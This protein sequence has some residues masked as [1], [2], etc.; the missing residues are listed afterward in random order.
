MYESS[1]YMFNQ[2]QLKINQNKNE[3]PIFKMDLN[4][5]GNK[6]YCSSSLDTIN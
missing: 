6:N 3:I 5:E 4:C 2:V 1:P